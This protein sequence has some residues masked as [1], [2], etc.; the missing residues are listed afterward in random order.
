MCRSTRGADLM[1]EYGSEIFGDLL[2]LLTL[3]V[4]LGL[5]GS[6]AANLFVIGASS[7]FSNFT[8]SLKSSVGVGFFSTI[9]PT[10]VGR[11]LN[12]CFEAIRRP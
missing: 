7:I 1:A 8:T 10:V 9:N 4:V 3:G 2:K 12:H 5:C 11:V 6:F